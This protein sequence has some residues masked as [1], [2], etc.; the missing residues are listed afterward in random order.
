MIDLSASQFQ[1]ITSPI[2]F[3]LYG[4]NASGASGTFSVNDFT[5]NGA[6]ALPIE[7]ISFQSKVEKTSIVLNFSTATERNNDYFS[8]E[9]SADGRTFQEIGRVQGAGDSY[10]TRHYAFNDP[11]P[12]TGINYY[13]L[14]QVDFDGAFAYS[15]VVSALFGQNKQLVLAPMPASEHLRMQVDEATNTDSRW[16]VFD[17]NGRQMMAGELPAE[18]TEQTIEIGTL[19]EGIYVLRLTA[20]QTIYTERFRKI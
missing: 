17:L 18:T 12:L 6:T 20:G 15:P 10:T 13:R 1:N 19:P 16:Q 8:I 9:R 11:Q 5:F 14:R 2:T 4:W 3:R 7:L